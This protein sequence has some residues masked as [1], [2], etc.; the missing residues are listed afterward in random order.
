MARIKIDFQ[1]GLFEFEGKEEQLQQLLPFFQELSEFLIAYRNDPKPE[2][3]QAASQVRQKMNHQLKKEEEKPKPVER[4]P[5]ISSPK[6]A[7]ILSSQDEPLLFFFQQWVQ[8]C[9]DD[10][11]KEMR[12][13]LLFFFGEQFQSGMACD[14]QYLKKLAKKLNIDFSP[15]KE[16]YIFF[17]KKKWLYADRQGNIRITTKG[18]EM[19]LSL[20]EEVISE[21]WEQTK[22]KYPT[23]Q[24][25]DYLS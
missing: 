5:D 15:I 1:G 9:P 14:I 23:Y 25:P 7:E 22:K 18:R 4:A 6:A 8:L 17:M 2:Y 10:D 19:L 11:I 13:V 12:L 3:L 21:S 16:E 20:F 24:K